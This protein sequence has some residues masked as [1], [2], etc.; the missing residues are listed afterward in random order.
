[1]SW[2]KQIIELFLLIY[3]LA[4]DLFVKK[5]TTLPSRIFILRNNGL[6]DLLCA[7]P[8]FESLKK[9]YPNSKVMVGI[10]NWHED[11]LEGNPYID[12]V[13]RINAPWHNQFSDTK[14]VL[15]IL[16]YIF[17][18]K[19]VRMLKSKSID[20]AID[21][22]GS[23]WASLLFLKIQ[24][25]NRIGVKGYDG[26]FRGNTSYIE[27]D[28]KRHIVDACLESAKVLNGIKPNS[29]RPQIYLNDEEL[30]LG[31]L[32]WSIPNQKK[33]VIAPG[34]SFEEKCWPN[35]YY[36]DLIE[37][38]APHNYQIILLG[39]ND[40]KRLIA[41]INLSNQN[42]SITDLCGKCSL[43]ESASIVANADIVISN[44]S[45]MMHVS[46]SFNIP[47]V[48]LLG[49]W[50]ESTKL[51]QILWEHKYTYCSGKEID[52]GEKNITAPLE[53]FE[54]I[55]LLLREQIN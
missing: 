15:K 37:L 7:T 54:K 4:N 44:A 29:K 40:D 39:S 10:S 32:V 3:K 35:S 23:Q 28:D 21:V 18:S 26:G 22:L 47:N 2:K 6:G 42:N 16:N 36:K 33:I 41:E 30:L 17:F 9:R 38:L 48:V 14:N 34:G 50:F 24:I 45:F 25:P 1:M 8:M 51:H 12:E 55:Q 49:E 43:R 27:F 13:I 52:N 53:A 19:E 20:F 11:L 31:K 5:S 46:A